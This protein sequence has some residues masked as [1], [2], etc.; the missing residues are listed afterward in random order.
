MQKNISSAAYAYLRLTRDKRKLILTELLLTL[1]QLVFTGHPEGALGAVAPAFGI[2]DRRNKGPR[3]GL[4]RNNRCLRTPATGDCPR[5][6]IPLDFLGLAGIKAPNLTECLQADN[7][8][9]NNFAIR[10]DR[11][12]RNLERLSSIHKCRREMYS[13]V[14]VSCVY[15]LRRCR[16][17]RLAVYILDAC[18]CRHTNRARWPDGIYID[19]QPVRAIRCEGSVMLLDN[20][21]VETRPSKAAKASHGCIDDIGHPTATPPRHPCPKCKV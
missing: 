11:D 21:A 5:N 17:P 18:R 13:C 19:V 3:T 14:C 20:T 1:D 10:C 6:D 9:W 2:G 4:L 7:G 16:C 12:G 8:A 15:K